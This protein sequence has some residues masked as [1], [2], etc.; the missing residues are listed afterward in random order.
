MPVPGASPE[1][2]D[3]SDW[4]V[5][6]ILEAI[7]EGAIQPGERLTELEVAAQFGVSRAPVRD[8]IHKLEKLGVVVRDGSR[9]TYVR[10]WDVKDVYDLVVVLDSLVSLSVRLAAAHITPT[11]LDALEAI[12]EETKTALAQDPDN[13]LAQ[14]ALDAKFH[15][16]IA[17]AT[18]NRMLEEMIENLWLPHQL[19]HKE[20]LGRV[21]RAYSLQEH[22]ELLE[23]L[24]SGNPAEAEACARRHAQAGQK[25]LEEAIHSRAAVLEPR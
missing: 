19:Y 9:A 22:T 16:L 8:A 14:A 11:H 21:G 1:Y 13:L 17:R 24:R 12:L 15:V 3:L 7:K 20:F 2:R 10:S 25:A 18:G 4:A 23:A 5:T 6:K